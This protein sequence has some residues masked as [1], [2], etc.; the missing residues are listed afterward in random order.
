ML[1]HPDKNRESPDPGLMKSCFKTFPHALESANIFSDSERLFR[2]IPVSEEVN[3]PT[4]LRH[5]RRRADETVADFESA[6]KEYYTGLSNHRLEESEPHQQS[7]DQHS[8]RF[9]LDSTAPDD[10]DII[11]VDIEGETKTSKKDDYHQSDLHPEPS[12]DEKPEQR[13]DVSRQ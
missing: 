6:Q 13:H 7:D 12:V 5:Y 11:D 10:E 1:F 3:I 9:N 4:E 8:P 2:S